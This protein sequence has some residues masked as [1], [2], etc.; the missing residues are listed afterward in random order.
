MQ[1][2][3]AAARLSDAALR[4]SLGRLREGDPSLRVRDAARRALSGASPP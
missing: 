1:A 4:A 2:V 3:A